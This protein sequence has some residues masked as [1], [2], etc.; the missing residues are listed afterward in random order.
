MKPIKVA[1]WTISK[2]VKPIPDRRFD[3]DFIH[4]DYYA[5][6]DTSN[7]LSGSAMSVQDALIQ[8][9]Q[10]E[11]ELREGASVDASN[12][13][14][15]NANL[16]AEIAALGEYPGWLKEKEAENVKLTGLL[17]E[18]VGNSSMQMVDE[19]L[20]DRIGAALTGGEEG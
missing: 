15:E 18:V 8:I 13:T 6:G 5:E 3:F 20:C 7:G 9:I 16:K 10:I 4:D 1:G 11:Q 12:L 19:N 14:T 17:S 2:W